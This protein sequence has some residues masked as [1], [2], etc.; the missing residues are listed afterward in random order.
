MPATVLD[1]RQTAP[2][3]TVWQRVSVSGYEGWCPLA[4]LDL[5]P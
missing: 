1:Q 3:G 2:D 5:V 4:N